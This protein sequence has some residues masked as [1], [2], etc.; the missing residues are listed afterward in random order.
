MNKRLLALFIFLLSIQASAAPTWIS[1]GQFRL[2]SGQWD[3]SRNNPIRLSNPIISDKLR[4][5]FSNFCGDVNVYNTFFKMDDGTFLEQSPNQH[6]DL[7][8]HQEVFFTFSPRKVV[9]I[10]FTAFMNGDCTFVIDQPETVIP[11]P[12]PPGIP[13][14][15]QCSRISGLMY[16]TYGDQLDQASAISGAPPDPCFVF[17]RFK[18]LLDY[19]FFLD[20]RRTKNLSPDFEILMPDNVKITFDVRVQQ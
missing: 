15:L 4:I 16:F 5:S 7:G 20:D 2:T 12:P 14:N 3:Y 18:S 9:G 10:G 8:N 17:M 11:P 19:R 13:S 1:T 6:I